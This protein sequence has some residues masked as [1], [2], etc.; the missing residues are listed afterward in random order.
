MASRAAQQWGTFARIWY[1]LDATKQPPGRIASM[2]SPIL[3]GKHKPIYHPL[4]DL[5][6]HVVIINTR[7]IAFSGDKWNTKLYHHHTG[8]PKGFS[9]TKARVVHERDPTKIIHKAVYGMLP[10]NLLRRT[11]MQRLHL[12]PD[13]QIPRDIQENIVEQLTP[14]RVVPRR[15]DQYTQEEIDNFPKLWF[16]EDDPDLR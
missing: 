6:D 12:F 14:P 10:K 16:P 2:V 7:H 11:M 1:L 8:Y 9:S 15:L 4:S 5:G 13:A 3:Q